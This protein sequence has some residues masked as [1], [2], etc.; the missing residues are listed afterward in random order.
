M[1][2]LSRSFMY[3]SLTQVN[4][5]LFRD[6][7][8]G[9]S[10]RKQL[11]QTT[12]RLQ[13]NSCLFTQ[14]VSNKCTISSRY[15]Q[16]RT[17]SQSN[18]S[19]PPPPPPEEKKNENTNKDDSE[20]SSKEEKTNPEDQ[21]RFKTF[22]FYAGL[23]TIGTSVGFLLD[24]S[25]PIVRTIKE[26]V[27]AMK[28]NKDVT[29][30]ESAFEK[31]DLADPQGEITDRV[32]LDIQFG[33]PAEGDGTTLGGRTERIII[34]LY[35]KECPKTTQN[36]KSLCEGY[37]A[38]NGQTL[39][40][41]GSRFHRIIPDFMIQ[42]GDYTAGNGTGGRSIYSASAPFPDESFRFKHRGLGVVS[43]AN[44]G[45]NTNTSQFF[46]CLEATP[47]LD[48]RH[49][50]FGQV[51]N[52]VETLKRCEFF[53]SRSGQVSEDIRIINSG[54]LPKLEETLSANS[55]KNEELDE[56]GHSIRRIMK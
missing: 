42:G 43:M 29:A 3:T 8:R 10:T 38:G 31:R 45:P 23:F 47:W 55:E 16:V 25:H 9:Y 37:A 2:L 34:G 50:V 15:V 41:K 20:N 30:P 53:G 36:F 28:E 48:G 11:L 44:R 32:F 26:K 51:L 6:V 54:V 46:I 52:G 17:L 24:E 12:N 21:N 5:A 35:G 19:M 7:Q 27:L 14:H 39:T 18:D 49:V 33:H 40:Y 1:S 13:L 56:M 22:A 4:R